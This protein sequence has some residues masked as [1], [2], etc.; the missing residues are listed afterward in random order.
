MK[1]GGGQQQLWVIRDKTIALGGRLVADLAAFKKSVMATADA[2]RRIAELVARRDELDAAHDPLA[3]YFCRK[4]RRNVKRM[5][6]SQPQSHPAPAPMP[7]VRAEDLRDGG[8]PG[9]QR[10]GEGNVLHILSPTILTDL[11]ASPPLVTPA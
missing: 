10:K 5:A 6:P 8:G 11:T 7:S 4:A 9:Q 1:V 3:G 2:D